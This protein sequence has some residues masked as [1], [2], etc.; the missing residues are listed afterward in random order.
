MEVGRRVRRLLVQVTRGTG[1]KG[2]TGMHPGVNE[3][4]RQVQKLSPSLVQG[5]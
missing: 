5:L 3:W 1:R 2:R 4:V